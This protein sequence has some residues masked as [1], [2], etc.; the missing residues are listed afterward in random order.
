MPLYGSQMQ[1]KPLTKHV[2]YKHAPS[3]I[4]RRTDQLRANM[5]IQTPLGLLP[6]ASI[7]YV[8]IRYGH[9]WW[10]MQL[11]YKARTVNASTFGYTEWTC[12]IPF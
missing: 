3:F 12:F 10:T 9:T 11:E 4:T 7:V 1:A 5:R 6:I 8:G 2:K